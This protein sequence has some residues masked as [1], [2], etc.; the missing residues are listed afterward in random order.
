M[1]LRPARGGALGGLDQR[2]D[3]P[4]DGN[5]ESDPEHPVVPFTERRQPEVEPARYVE[6]AQQNPEEGHVGPFEF[7][8]GSWSPTPA[9]RVYGG[10]SAFASSLSSG[11]RLCTVN[12]RPAI[13]SS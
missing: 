3:D 10:M 5:D 1:R 2:P 7:A 8:P 11:V 9:D 4:Q 13:R 12:P 6:D